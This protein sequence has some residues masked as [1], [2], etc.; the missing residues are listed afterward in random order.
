[1]EILAT[2]YWTPALLDNFEKA[3]GYSLLKYLPVLFR[4]DNNWGDASPTY[5]EIFI[6]ANSTAVNL[7]Y[8]RTLS[9]GYHEYLTYINDWAKQV[10]TRG[11]S[12]QPAYNLP[13]DMVRA[14][15]L[16]CGAPWSRY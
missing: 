15:V 13:L 5:A 10:G 16:R 9:E 11:Y 1:M 4:P 8:R 6:S 12:A 14:E 2:L 7:D 3:R